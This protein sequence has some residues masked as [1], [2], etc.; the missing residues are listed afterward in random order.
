MI[1][2]LIWVT[3]IYNWFNRRLM[4]RINL[5]N[6]SLWRF[7]NLINFIFHLSVLSIFFIKY[8]KIFSIDAFE[9]NLKIKKIFNDF[10]KTNFRVI[11]LS[12]NFKIM[13]F[14]FDSNSMYICRFRC[15]IINLTTT[16][17]VIRNIRRN[18]NLNKT[19]QRFWLK[20]SSDEVQKL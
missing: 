5:Y 13:F 7:W 9:V 6:I 3:K 2:L 18:V 17:N 14:F 10:R 20:K 1:F 8:R 11:L 16:T 4:M 19:S 15:F 12:E